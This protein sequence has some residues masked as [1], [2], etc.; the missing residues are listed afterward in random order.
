MKPKIAIVTNIAWNLYN[1]RRDLARALKEAGYEPVLIAY[2]DNYAAKLVEEG[3]T[4][5]PMKNMER[6]G[7]NPAKDIQLLFDFINTYKRLNIA[8]AL[9]YNAKPL[10]YA[11]FAASYLNIPYIANITG[12]A[13]PFS[14]NRALISKVVGLLYKRA[15]KNSYKVVFQNKDDRA[16]FLD[17]KLT[18]ASKTVLIPGSGVN[19][20]KF[21]ARLFEVPSNDKLIFLMFSRLSWAKGIAYYVDA[22]RIVKRKY[23]GVEFKLMGPFDSD[24][25]AIKKEQVEEWQKEGAIE[26]LG[27]SDNVQ[28][29]ICKADVI[30]YPSYYMEGLPKSLIESAAMSKPIITTDNVGC[31][32]AVDDGVNGFLVPVKDSAALVEACEKLINM[33][34]E[35]RAK[36]GEASRKIAVDRFDE[37]KVLGIY[38]NLINKIMH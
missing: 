17:K 15:F 34:A 38:L 37:K 29:E 32:E 35:E 31:R 25:L 27:V 10:V 16:F 11:S 6:T 21:D 4:F 14:G 26:Y 33:P 28:R 3:W 12:L 22:A 36:M 24:K 7:I 5:V 8:C 9:H 2:P 1:F 13:G 18:K 20:D 23:P 19:M 30:V